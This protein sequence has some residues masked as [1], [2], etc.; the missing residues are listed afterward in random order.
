MLGVFVCCFVLCFLYVFGCL[1]AFVIL[2]GY[3]SVM[4]FPFWGGFL[5]L[6]LCDFGIL[7]VVLF[8]ICMW[9]LWSVF[10][11]CFMILCVGVY[12]GSFRFLLFTYLVLFVFI[13][14]C[15]FCVLTWGGAIYLFVCFSFIRCIF[16]VLMFDH[17]ITKRCGE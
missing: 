9:A 4:F 11:V 5:S 7:C 15:F 8:F 2:R 16:W 6:Y 10:L 3:I 17:I 1:Y 12:L 14:C 13:F